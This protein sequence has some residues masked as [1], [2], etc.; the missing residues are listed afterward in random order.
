MTAQA[1]RVGF[2]GLRLALTLTLLTAGFVGLYLLSRQNYLF[3]HT[4]VEV[5]SIVVAFSVFVF[6]WSCRDYLEHNFLLFLGVGYLFIGAMDLLHSFAYK[7][8]HVFAV[9]DTNLPTQLW[10]AGRY[11][12]AAAWVGGS[13]L[14]GR[15]T[16]S[17]ATVAGFAALFLLLVGGIFWWR[18]FPV[19]H[20]QGSGLTP[21]KVGSEYAVCL[22][23]LLAIALLSRRRDLLD[24]RLYLLLVWS[25]IVTVLSELSFTLYVDVYG[26]LNFLGHYL[27]IISTYLLLIATIEQGMRRPFS[28]LFLDL[29]RSHGELEKERE[30]LDERVQRRTASLHEHQE[31]LRSL[32]SELSLAEERERRRIATE[33][34]DN[35]SQTLAFAK[36]QL[37]ALR[38]R[39]EAEA[40]GPELQRLQEAIDSAVA[41]SRSVTFELSPP[42]L[43]TMGL[44]AAVEW[45][46]RQAQE[47]HGVQFHFETDQQPKPLRDEVRTILFQA[48]REI[49]NNMGKHAQARNAWARLCASDGMLWVEIE[50][51]GVGFD[52]AAVEW[53]PERTSGFGLFNMQERL[54]HLGGQVLIHSAPGQ[55]AKFTLTAPLDGPSLQSPPGSTSP[56]V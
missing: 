19:A 13:L 22:L 3:F 45:V 35:L 11:V 27:K 48:V 15:R 29:Q 44:E 49:F 50:D 21:F 12:V 41:D 14:I 38:H 7:G 2:Q 8:L 34:H 43:Y 31:R 24:R 17:K 10:V 52:P 6:A 55:G 33:I 30:L 9:Q 51:D 36:M 39:P 23:L 28:M 25:A 26:F 47:R 4:T 16:P 5:F 54:E 56:D 53:R 46:G 37:A 32:A 40:I 1:R 20:V 42:I 18:I